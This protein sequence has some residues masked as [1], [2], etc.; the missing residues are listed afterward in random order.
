MILQCK[1][2]YS[3]AV[4]VLDFGT[5]D[6]VSKPHEKTISVCQQGIGNLMWYVAPNKSLVE[7]E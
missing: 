3:V 1:W 2:R 5:K 4:K 7:S 6:L